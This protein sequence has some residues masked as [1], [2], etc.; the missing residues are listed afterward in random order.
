MHDWKKQVHEEKS[1]VFQRINQERNFLML[2]GYPH[3]RCASLVTKL[4]ILLSIIEG[5]L[6]Q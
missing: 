4:L 2:H 5:I 3:V 1:Y 6:K